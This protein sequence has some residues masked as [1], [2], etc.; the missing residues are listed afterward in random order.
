MV[1]SVDVRE[2]PDKKGD[3]ATIDVRSPSEFARG[4]IPCAVNIPLFSDI[5]RAK[6][7]SVYRNSGREAA[8]YKGLE[9]TGPGMT[10]YLKELKKCTKEKQVLIHCWRGGMRSEA[11]AWLFS[12]AGHEVYV[13]HGGYKAYRKFIRSQFGR[14]EKLIVI[15]GK[16]GSGKSELL[17]AVGSAGRQ[18]IDLEEIACHKGSAFGDLGQPPQPT[19]EQFENDL[20]EHF[21]KLDSD[22]P[23]WVENESRSIGKV[24]IPD[25]LFRVMENS[26]VINV[27]LPDEIRFSRLV[28]EYAAFDNEP[29]IRAVE[30]IAQRLGGLNTQK[31]IRAI[32][33]GDYREAVAYI[34]S[35]YDKAYL[36]GL[37]SRDENRVF[38]LEFNGDDM[39][40]NAGSIIEFYEKNK[41]KMF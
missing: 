21:R 12:L 11:M 37:E 23:V 4:H 29:L 13:L 14:Y 15:G 10:R 22:K 5:E 26:P 31:S 41:T 27:H 38:H 7:G 30:K 8:I 17:H 16:T 25:T 34:L 40:H 24:S 20:Y 9:I 28:N 1:H 19:N 2:F 35:Y 32:E 33:H 36:K 18:V 6:V 39:E 3:V